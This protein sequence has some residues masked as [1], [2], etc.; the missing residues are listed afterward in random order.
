MCF[1]ILLRYLYLTTLTC[2]RRL[3]DRKN[4]EL[5]ESMGV[6]SEAECVA[7]TNVTLD[8]YTG[9]VEME[10]LCLINMIDQHIIPS[11][12]LAGLDTA[13][14]IACRKTLEDKLAAV[15]AAADESPLAAGRQ[16]RELRL[17]VMEDGASSQLSE[18]LECLF[19]LYLSEGA[20]G[21]CARCATR[22][23]GTFQHAIGL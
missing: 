1:D 20:R 14:L 15:H 19:L 8:H 12:S 21:Q 6:L 11:A 13:E 7:R 18:S 16:A 23:K 17:E 22:L 10:A 5:F 3:S 9:F 4:V 2:T